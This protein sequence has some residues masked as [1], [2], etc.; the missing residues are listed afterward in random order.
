M[1]DHLNP[2]S[3]QNRNPDGNG[4]ELYWDK[5]DEVWPKNP[6]GSI[7]MYTRPMDLVSLRS[8]LT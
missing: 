4:I 1:S 6:D 2:V 7:D 8:E 5:P 3:T